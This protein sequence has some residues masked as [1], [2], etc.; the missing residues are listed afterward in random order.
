MPTLVIWE[1]GPMVRGPRNERDII[2]SF[3]EA[4][5][6]L[7]TEMDERDSEYCSLGDWVISLARRRKEGGR[8]SLKE[9]NEFGFEQVVFDM[10]ICHLGEEV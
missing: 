5:R 4:H 2:S 1:T 8:T 6:F 10:P 9:R 3:K 7:V